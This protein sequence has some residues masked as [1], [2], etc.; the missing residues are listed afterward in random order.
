MAKLRQRRK[1]TDNQADAE[2][3]NIILPAATWEAASI[4]AVKR[5]CTLSDVIVAALQEHLKL[6]GPKA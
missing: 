3:V 2:R 1:Q 4:A 5:R 6:K